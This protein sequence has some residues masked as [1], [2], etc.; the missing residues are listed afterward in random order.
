MLTTAQQQI[1]T[2]LGDTFDNVR[3]LSESR[4]LYASVMTSDVDYKEYYSALSTKWKIPLSDIQTLFK[5]VDIYEKHF[6][7][8]EVAA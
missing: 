7:N 1:K 3:Q 4:R 2:L 6:V 5:S 8:Q